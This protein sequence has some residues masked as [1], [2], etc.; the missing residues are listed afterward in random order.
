MQSCYSG[1][2]VADPIFHQNAVNPRPLNSPKLSFF[3][4]NTP[5][6]YLA[7]QTVFVKHSFQDPRMISNINLLPKQSSNMKI[8]FKQDSS[9][10]IQTGV[11]AVGYRGKGTQL[12]LEYFSSK[13]FKSPLSKNNFV[14][15]LYSFSFI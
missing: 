3:R 5:Q 2:P 7:A 12:Y 4:K 10:R 8:Q 14:A 13:S 9:F 11:F 6:G 15:L 1:R